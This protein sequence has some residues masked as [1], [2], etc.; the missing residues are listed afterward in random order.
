MDAL[1][2]PSAPW[3]NIG[4][5]APGPAR[6]AVPRLAAPLDSKAIP[7]GLVAGFVGS[8]LGW[9]VVR[10]VTKRLDRPS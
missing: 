5:D 2:D 9:L 4:D 8:I 1:P 6:R 7:L 3:T 10:W